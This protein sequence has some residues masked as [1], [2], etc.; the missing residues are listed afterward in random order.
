MFLLG[1]SPGCFWKLMLL[2]LVLLLVDGCLLHASTPC[3]RSLHLRQQ[4][5]CPRASLLEKLEPP[6][7]GSAQSPS[8]A[9][10][11][12]AGQQQ[13]LASLLRAM[14][15]SDAPKAEPRPLLRVQLGRS[16]DG[17]P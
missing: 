12:L 2:L 10:K 1:V 5:L 8:G 11:I 16:L 15:F 13:V 3:S 4:Q 6:W 7:H 14:T 9:G 17:C